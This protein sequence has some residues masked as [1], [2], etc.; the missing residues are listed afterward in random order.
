MAVFD[1]SKLP[2]L[3]WLRVFEAAARL[4]NFTAAAAELNLTQAAVSQRIRLLESQLGTKLFERLPRGVTL[5]LAG[6]AYLPHVQASLSALARATTDVFGADRRRITIAAAGSAILLWIVPRLERLRRSVPRTTIKFVTVYREPDYVTAHAD[7]DVRFG[8]G[9]W[10]GRESRLLFPEILA[11]VAAPSL[12]AEWPDWREAPAIGLAGPRQGWLEWS[13]ETGK[14][15]PRASE[16]RF[17]SFLQVREAALRGQGIMLGSL[18]LLEDDFATGRLV[19][20]DEP[21][22]TMRSG[23]WLTWA[24]HDLPH[25]LVNV[26]FDALSG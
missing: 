8:D 4:A 10:S 17:D 24:E 7:F 18:G 1:F 6:E 21:S 20:L 3:E 19:R 15:P 25:R 5:T 9:V 26:V 23:N 14:L 13:M 22:I 11:P 16:I 12:L 2:P